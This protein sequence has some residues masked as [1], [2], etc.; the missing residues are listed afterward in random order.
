MDVQKLKDQF[1]YRPGGLTSSEL[2]QL[3]AIARRQ[4]NYWT[5]ASYTPP[6]AAVQPQAVVFFDLQ[7]A[8][9]GKEVDLSL[10]VGYSRNAPLNFGAPGCNNKQ[11][12][13]VVLNGNA[14]LVCNA[15]YVAQLFVPAAGPAN[16]TLDL[17]GGANII[18]TLYATRINQSGNSNFQ[19]DECF[20]KNLNGAQFTVTQKNFRELDRP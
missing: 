11:V 15:T 13:M 18:G 8:E 6:N 14:K 10:P 17:G 5:T 12:I 16:G 7:G 19:L 9:V 4:G 3:R 20:L 1:Q 2:D